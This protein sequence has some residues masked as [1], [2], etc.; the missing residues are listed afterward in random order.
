MENSFGGDTFADG[1]D[2]LFGYLAAQGQLDT[3]P[4]P[5]VGRHSDRGPNRWDMAAFPRRDV[6]VTTCQGI[7]IGENTHSLGEGNGGA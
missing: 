3:T 2:G 7:G 4:V 1:P 6:I 5:G